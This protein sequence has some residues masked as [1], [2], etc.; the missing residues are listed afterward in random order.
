VGTRAPS[1]SSTSALPDAD[2]TER[3]MC[4]ATRAPAAAATKA[5]QVDTL[6]VCETSP[7]V[8]QVSTRW[9]SSA[10]RTGV[11]NSRITCA[12]AAISPT[13]SR[14]TR[15]PITNP[16]ICAGVSSP[17]ISRRITASI[18]SWSSSRWS[19]ARWMASAIEIGFIAP[20]GAEHTQPGR[21]RR[22]LERRARRARSW[23]PVRRAEG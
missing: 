10:T 17:R 3:P 4:L 18:S 19:T 20:P 14:F 13:V 6:N 15:R 7:P 11:A 8:P 21:R 1:A 9:R 22:Q 2:E 5:A 12:A 23:D 16:A